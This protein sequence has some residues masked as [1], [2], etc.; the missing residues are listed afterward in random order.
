MVERGLFERFPV[1]Q[2]FGMHNWPGL[3][4]GTFGA[5]AGPVMASAD[6]FEIE[7]TGRG[8]HAA[9]PHLTIDPVV[10]GAAIVQSLQ[11]LASRIVDPLESAVVSVTQFHAGDAYNVIPEKATLRG[12]ARAFRPAVRDALEAGIA[13]I[14]GAVAGAHGV[15]ASVRYSRGYPPTIN[16]AEQARFCADVASELVGADRVFTDLAPSMGAEDFSFM[17][18]KKP[19][20]YVWLGAGGE[21]NCMLHNP[22]F[23][24]N[25]A[26]LPL[27]VAYWVR[28]VERALAV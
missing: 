13:R 19:G 25:D 2:V 11:T 4:P 1:D 15:T 14:A 21:G 26:V 28:L 9:M 6:E 12:T 7:L 23:D 20:C 10:A 27:G 3:P 18:E 24:F 17:L 22:R 5:V 16:S 8:G